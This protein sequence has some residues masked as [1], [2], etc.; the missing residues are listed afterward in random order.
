M[1]RAAIDELKM[2]LPQLKNRVRGQLAR[3]FDMPTNPAQFQSARNALADRAQN[4]VMHVSDMDLKAFCLRLIDSSLPE[5]EWIES[6][7]SLVAATPPSRWKDSDE[8]VFTERLQPVVKKFLRVENLCFDTTRA[9]QA[10]ATFR[11]DLTRTDGSEKNQVLHLQPG[12]E[13]AVQRLEQEIAALLESHST[14]IS[15]TALSQNLWKL[16]ERQP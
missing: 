16:M 3:A 12:E 15:L 9:K 5:A 6:V 14:P 8:A 1:L 7:G 10:R 4:M 13:S 2:A 11:V